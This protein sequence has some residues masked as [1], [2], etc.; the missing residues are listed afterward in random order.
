MMVWALLLIAVI[1]AY[2]L[3]LIDL[4][5]WLKASRNL[6]TFA[7][8]LYIRVDLLPDALHAVGETFIIALFGTV[9]GAL[10]SYPLSAMSA[11]GVT[12][13]WL[14]LAIRTVSN[15]LRTVPAIFWGILFV[16][17]FGPGNVAGA[18]A[19][20]L[21][22]AGYLSKFFYETFENVNKEHY[23]ALGSLALPWMVMAKALFKHTEKQM[24]SHT[25]F[26]FEYNLRTASI[27][28]IVGAGGIGYY[29]TQYV[30]ILNYAAA[31]TLF[32]VILLFVFLVDGVSYIIRKKM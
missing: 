7:S 18:V 3:G 26:M 13:R 32:M 20:A 17:M 16:V 19:L 6:S 24:V 5:S 31:F 25:M 29:I 30:S 22:T 4:D 27:L 23:E 28:G 14:S 10:I 12:A 1:L 9:V 21:Y 8:D 11:Q 2:F 15:V